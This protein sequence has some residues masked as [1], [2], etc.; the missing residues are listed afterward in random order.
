MAPFA[1]YRQ[2]VPSKPDRVA[3]ALAGGFVVLL[4]AT[5]LILSLPDEADSPEFVANFPALGVLAAL[6]AVFCLIRLVL[7]IAG[8]DRGPLDAIGPLSFLILIAVMAMLSYLSIL[9]AA[10]DDHE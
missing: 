4:L 3:G 8:R 9:R 7:Q 5:E 2:R 1:A 6:V 10:S